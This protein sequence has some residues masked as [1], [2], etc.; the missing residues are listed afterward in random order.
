MT[1]CSAT[2]AAATVRSRTRQSTVTGTTGGWSLTPIP[3]CGMAGPLR[4]LELLE[5][6]VR[7]EPARVRGRRAGVE[8]HADEALAGDEPDHPFVLGVPVLVGGRARPDRGERGDGEEAED[9][10]ALRDRRPG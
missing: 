10:G 7:D 4:E 3:R 9:V 8:L 5:A 6:E 2:V 1:Y